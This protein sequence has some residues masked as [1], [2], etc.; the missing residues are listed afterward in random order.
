VNSKSSV[1]SGLR[2][3]KIE[4]S[5]LFSTPFCSATLPRASRLN[6]S[7]AEAILEQAGDRR[8]ESAVSWTSPWDFPDLGSGPGRAVAAAARG[9]ASKLCQACG[10]KPIPPDAWRVS[11]RAE[12]IT[13]ASA[14]VGEPEAD[15][16][17]LY[18]VA[19]DE[20]ANGSDPGGVLE[21]QDPRGP[22]PVMYA[23]SVTF[24]GPGSDSLGV[25][26]TLN[27]KPG[28]LIVYPALLPQ[29]FSFYRGPVPHITLRFRIES[30]ERD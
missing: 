16:T 26:Q 14:T 3:G 27:M 23:P 29:S 5:T 7:L 19:K 6:K 11:C 1:E 13:G 28:L 24:R 9:L 4:G 25:T 12:V 30:S 18:I 22:A 17:G 20:D 2:L 10:Q 21:L 8:P 15:F